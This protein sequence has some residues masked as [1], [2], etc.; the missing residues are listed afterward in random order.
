MRFA[1]DAQ[2]MPPSESSISVVVGV[3]MPGS[4]SSSR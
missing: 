2:V 3:L 1:H 4:P